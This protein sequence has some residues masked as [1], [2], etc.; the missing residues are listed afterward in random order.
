MLERARRTDTTATETEQGLFYPRDSGFDG[1][2]PPYDQVHNDDE[3][4]PS[5]ET[6]GYGN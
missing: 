5:Y 6:L 4:P 2:P 1:P 3:L